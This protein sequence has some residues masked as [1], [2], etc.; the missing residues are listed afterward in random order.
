[1]NDQ[2]LAI[3]K[4]AIDQLNA[5]ATSQQQ[6]IDADTSDAAVAQ[7][8]LDKDNADIAT[9][10][11]DRSNTLSIV[12]QLST[13]V[14]NPPAPAPSP[15]PTPEPAPLAEPVVLPQE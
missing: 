6:T 2:A 5:L 7:A 4:G 1:M 12:S 13:L 3:V 14:T 11:A 10:Q 9:Q 15:T 8:K